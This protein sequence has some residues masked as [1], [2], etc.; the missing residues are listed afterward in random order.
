MQEAAPLAN[1]SLVDYGLAIPTLEDAVSYENCFK[2]FYGN[3]KYYFRTES[4]YSFRRW[5]DA[6][7][8]SAISRKN[9]DCVTA[10][11]LRI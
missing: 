9:V 11:S 1:L 6:I 3:Y 5:M 7:K 10:L 8:C 2:L 4:G